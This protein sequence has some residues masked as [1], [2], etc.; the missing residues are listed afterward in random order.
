MSPW[1]RS[2]PATVLSAR[3]SGA[4]AQNTPPRV[5]KNQRRINRHILSTVAELIAIVQKLTLPDIHH[6]TVGKRTRTTN[7]AAAI[8]KTE[9]IT[10]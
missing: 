10:S 1:L 5:F 4:G 6:L 8:G 9:N 3:L 2:I 7:T